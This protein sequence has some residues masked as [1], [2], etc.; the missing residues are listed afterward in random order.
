MVTNFTN[1]SFNEM[2]NYGV[3]SITHVNKP[4]TIYIGSTKCRARDKLLKRKGFIRRWEQH[5]YLLNSNRHYCKYLQ[6]VVNKY[7]INGLQFSI[8]EVVEDI[9]I[10][11]DREQ[12]YIDLYKLKYSL[13]N[14]SL[15][16]FVYIREH[17]TKE[18]IEK[19]KETKKLNY[20]REL[21]PLSTKVYVYTN[22]GSF[23]EECICFREASEKYKVSYT[24]I[25]HCKKE[26]IKLVGN[27]LFCIRLLSDEEVEKFKNN[28]VTKSWRRMKKVGQYLNGELIKIFNSAKEVNETFNIKNKGINQVLNRK[29][30]KYLGYEWK[31]I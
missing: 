18:S 8:I 31:Y 4:N 29:N 14:N 10:I 7:G 25:G 26:E 15:T 6:N 24:A 28:P 9:S 21:H 27:Y 2:C 13:Y 3:Y 19:Q 16:A 5:L 22:N 30:N 20:K 12:H 1:N 17:I 11:F 23:L